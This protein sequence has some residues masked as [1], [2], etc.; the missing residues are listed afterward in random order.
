MGR[1][2]G[3]RALWRRSVGGAGIS[4]AQNFEVPYA[5]GIPGSIRVIY[6]PAAKAVAVEHLEKQS[7]Y[8]A[9]WFDPVTGFESP[10]PPIAANE[11]GP[12]MVQPP[13]KCDH[14]WVV[15]LKSP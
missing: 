12:A 5:A 2:K 11:S 3:A 10:A 4:P 13:D 8:I 1:R 9:T 6:A 14:D 15:I 7:R